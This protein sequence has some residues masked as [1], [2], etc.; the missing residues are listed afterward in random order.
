MGH[1]D[2]LR[3]IE[4]SLRKAKLPIMYSQGF[5]P[6]MKLSFGP[7]LPLGFTSETEIFEATFESNFM[8]YLGEKFKNVMPDG[9][10]ILESKVI[11]GKTKSLSSM[12]NRITYELNINYITSPAELKEKIDTFLD[13]EHYEFDRKKKS[14]TIIIDIRPAVHELIIKDD[15]LSMTL[16]NSDGGYVKPGEVLQVLLKDKFDK[17]LLNQI[18]RKEMFRIDENK[19]KILLM[20]I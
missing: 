13:C 6:T 12:I 19:Q 10:D 16:G 3:L 9:F 17:F 8:S 15:C 1:Q 5:H 2:N 14:E 11:M 7:P 20:D 18:H 4:R